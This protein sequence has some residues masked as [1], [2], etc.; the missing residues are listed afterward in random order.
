MAA[1]GATPPVFAG[2]E[3]LDGFRAAAGRAGVPLPPERVRTV[4][5]LRGERE[6]RAVASELLDG[7][8]PP[9]AVV[10]GT[11][12]LA[13]ALLA[14]ARD[15]GLRVP[16]DVAVVSFDEPAYAELLDPPVTSL[17]RHDRELGR[18]VAQLL[19]DALHGAPGTPEVLRVPL[20]LRVRRSCGCGVDRSDAS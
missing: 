17:D 10:G 2:R 6:V 8:Q 11:D 7:E 5:P 16:D 1:E 12:T 14:A 20:V 9:T 19:L 4:D 18:R 3:R 13:M 15:A